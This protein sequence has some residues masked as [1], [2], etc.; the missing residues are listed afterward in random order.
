MSSVYWFCGETFRHFSTT[1]LRSQEWISVLWRCSSLSG[2]VRFW[3]DVMSLD[4]AVINWTAACQF[5]EH[6]IDVRVVHVLQAP[7]PASKAAYI[8]GAPVCSDRACHNDDC[9]TRT[10]WRGLRVHS[11]VLSKG[12]F[13]RLLE[14][15]SALSNLRTYWRP[16]S[17]CLVASATVP[18]CA[19][20]F[21]ATFKIGWDLQRFKKRKKVFT[22]VLSGNQ[23]VVFLIQHVRVEH[24][25]HHFE[26]TRKTDIFAPFHRIFANVLNSNVLE[27]VKLQ[28]SCAIGCSG[29]TKKKCWVPPVRRTDADFATSGHRQGWT[30][31]TSITSGWKRTPFIG[32]NGSIVDLSESFCTENYK[33]KKKKNHKM[34]NL[35]IK[36]VP[37]T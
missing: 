35:E 7:S 17:V 37:H 23:C 2:A 26:I 14:S 25:C 30:R 16:G 5:G 32:N 15:F 1:L 24:L 10:W 3:L 22:C 6:I 28:L 33:N 20:V 18:C 11:D 31:M 21:G 36:Q 34:N 4:V 27:K 9:I 8:S 12:A 13:S 19:M 29:T